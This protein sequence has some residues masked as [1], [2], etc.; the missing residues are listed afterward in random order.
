MMLEY[1]E[2]LRL[3]SAKARAKLQCMEGF[4]G[5][6]RHLVELLSGIVKLMGP[7]VAP[8]PR[9]VATVAQVVTTDAITRGVPKFMEVQAQAR[10]TIAELTVA[11]HQVLIVARA[12]QHADINFVSHLLCT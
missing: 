8:R 12:I 7:G 4:I 6:V 3:T 9:F 11:H 1:T 2:V 10:G 5:V